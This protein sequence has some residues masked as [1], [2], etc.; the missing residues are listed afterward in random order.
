MRG[1]LEPDWVVLEV[2]NTG[3]GI[4]RDQLG[5]IFERFYRVDAGR[6]REMGGTGLGLSIVRHLVGRMGGSIEAESEQG[7]WTRMRLRLGRAGVA[8]TQTLPPLPA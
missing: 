2:E 3:P 1:R 7:Q 8:S 4:P 6:S 5:R